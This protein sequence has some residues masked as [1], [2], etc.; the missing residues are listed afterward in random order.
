M[1]VKEGA[2]QDQAIAQCE[3]MWENRK[4]DI[5]KPTENVLED[6]IKDLVFKHQRDT[7]QLDNQTKLSFDDL[8]QMKDL[9]QSQ[10]AKSMWVNPQVKTGD[11]VGATSTPPDLRLVEGPGDEEDD[12]PEAAVQTHDDS[13]QEPSHEGR[14]AAFG[15][16][17]REMVN[18]GLD[19]TDMRQVIE[20]ETA[21][22]PMVALKREL[23]ENRVA[24][25]EIKELLDNGTL[26]REPEG[27][28]LPPAPPAEDV[29][30]ELLT[31]MRQKADEKAQ[32]RLG[33]LTARISSLTED[34]SQPE[35][36]MSP[37]DVGRFLK[38]ELLKVRDANLSEIRSLV[39][40]A[41]GTG[42]RTSQADE[43]R[44]MIRRALKR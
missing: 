16:Y 17:V 30:R 9:L 18:S 27:D 39:K 36:E 33:E 32:N 26:K 24:L 4:R 38:A 7:L 12:L 6:L 1:V 14:L 3:S 25:A 15:S 11:M 44:D 28:P 10:E 42:T 29:A 20:T 22:H 21:E 41:G 43:I 23:D 19:P 2:D 13:A 5:E 8:R 34:V 37:G 31:A 40:Q 35:K